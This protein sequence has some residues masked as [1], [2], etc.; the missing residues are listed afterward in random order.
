LAGWGQWV[1]GGRATASP[2]NGRNGDWLRTRVAESQQIRALVRCL[3]PFSTG[4]QGAS[5]RPAPLV[6]KRA[7]QEGAEGN[8]S[9]TPFS[10]QHRSDPA[11]PPRSGRHNKAQGRAAHPGA[12]SPNVLYA[13]GV[14]HP[15]VPTHRRQQIGRDAHR[16]CPRRTAKSRGL[17]HFSVSKVLWRTCDARKHGPVPLLH[18]LA[19]PLGYVRKLL[20]M[21]VDSQQ[22]A[23][24]KTR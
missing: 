15:S 6:P 19:V 5:R 17:V 12:Q 9:H 13:E 22:L 7:D 18:D 16:L 21:G 4:S 8:T 10:R 23:Q 1:A 3:S 24:P 20:R 14:P 2:Q 11:L